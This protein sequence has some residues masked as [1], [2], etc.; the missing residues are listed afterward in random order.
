MSIR[1]AL[2]VM[3]GLTLIGVVLAAQGYR[4]VAA[5]VSV[6]TENAVSVKRLSNQQQLVGPIR[7]LR[8]TLF[9]AGIRPGEM[10]IKA[11]VV[12]IHIEDRTHTSKGVTIQRAF[13]AERVA[14]GTV[15]EVATESR[16]RSSFTLSP[17][18]YELF[19]VSQPTRKAVLVV[20]P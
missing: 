12:N 8:F 4:K 15:Q 14:V 2:S 5:L 16:G 3:T 18:Q 19:D 10:R 13:G 11:G 7:N 17:G 9:E 20:E 6:P 1:Y